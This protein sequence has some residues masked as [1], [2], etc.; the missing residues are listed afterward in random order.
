MYNN[1]H[2]FVLYSSSLTPLAMSK[3]DEFVIRVPASVATK[4]RKY[5]VLKFNGSL[6]IDITKYSFC[7]VFA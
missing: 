7:L 4:N 5:S 6:N 2:S 1:V 3:T